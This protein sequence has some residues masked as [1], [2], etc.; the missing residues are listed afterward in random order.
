MSTATVPALASRTYIAP[1]LLLPGGIGFY[2]AGRLAISYLFFQAS[3]QTGTA[4]SLALNYLLLLA[5]AFYCCGPA[6]NTLRSM[7]RVLPFR[8]V[9]AF[10]GVSLVSLAW[11]ATI[12]VPVAL[13]YWGAMAAD[14]AMVLLLL[15]LSD[16]GTTARAILKGYVWGA[17]F[18]A[19]VMWLS[20][21]MEDLRP[22]DNEFF[23]PNAIGFI[24]AFAVFFA[25]YLTH[26]N[27]RWRLAAAFLAITLLRS[28]SKGTIIAFA[29]GELFLIL[30]DPT[31]RRRTKALIL[32]SS[33]AV[34][35]A[36][37]GLIVNYLAV[38][39]NAGNQ[40]ETL[41]GRIGIWAFV[42]ERAWEQPWFGHGFDSFRNVIPPF[43]SFEAWHAHNELI[44]Q[45]YAYGAVGIILL[46]GVYGSF[47]RQVRRLRNPVEKN[48]FL[49]LLLFIL[50]GGL[51]EAER[52]DLTFPLWS[53][54]LLSLLLAY[55]STQPESAA[56][57]LLPRSTA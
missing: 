34:V 42:L 23:S 52:F 51:V 11:S 47:Y 32:G 46:I 57:S 48:L 9:L 20:P 43:G 31:T 50:V 10:L 38:Y 36:F 29:A 28:L 25:H 3:P 2:F 21:T 27:P 18:I 14:V 44:Q 16:L 22:G 41:T 1:L 24:C 5:T 26:F 39:N 8:W 17:C 4:F 15:R 53:I 55:G 30:R 19:V 56:R 49:A 40:E 33:L 12:S 35:G 13:A 54:A 6:R 45:F 7:G 37:S